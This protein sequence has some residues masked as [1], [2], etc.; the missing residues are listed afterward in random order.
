MQD[1]TKDYTAAREQAEEFYKSVGNVR[2]PAL[3]GECVHFTSEGFNHLIYKSGKK[4][5]RSKPVQ[6]MKFE[7]L[8]K[9][10]ETGEEVTALLLGSGVEG[11]AANLG[12]ANR[13]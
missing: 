13:R 10:K 7:M 11:L 8:S 6:I 4:E 3:G 5:P 12:H 1:N 2:C 9:A